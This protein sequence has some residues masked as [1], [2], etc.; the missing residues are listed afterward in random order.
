MALRLSV[1]PLAERKKKDMLALY[2]HD[3]AADDL[4]SRY[5]SEEMQTE[6]KT[7]NSLM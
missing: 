1:G 5:A 2:A 7:T 3:D 4:M 6:M